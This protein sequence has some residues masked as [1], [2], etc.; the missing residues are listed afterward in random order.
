MRTDTDTQPRQSDDVWT[1]L[2]TLKRTEDEISKPLFKVVENRARRIAQRQGLR[3][4]K[5]RRR[6]PQAIDY[7]TYMLVDDRNRVVGGAERMNFGEVIAYL[8]S[9]AEAIRRLHREA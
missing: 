9:G 5:S 7:G 2:L 8:T 1:E 4:V 3:L 6:D